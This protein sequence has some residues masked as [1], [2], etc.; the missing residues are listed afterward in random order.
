MEG[1]RGR[2]RHKRGEAIPLFLACLLEKWPKPR[3]E[4]SRLLQLSVFLLL[5][6]SANVPFAALPPSSPHCYLF[7]LPL[8]EIR[9]FCRTL[10]EEEEDRG[11][12]KGIWRQ[13]LGR[14]ISIS[15]FSAC[16]LTSSPFLVVSTSE[17]SCFSVWVRFLLASARALVSSLGL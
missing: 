13:F 4:R 12:G 2:W 5:S 17:E 10:Q 9:K 1:G 16:L 8:W 6:S 7:G 11:R 14:G 15:F 3:E